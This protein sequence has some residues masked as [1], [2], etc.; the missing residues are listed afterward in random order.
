MSVAYLLR[1]QAGGMLATRVFLQPPT[2]AQMEAVGEEADSVFGPGWL[3][4][5]EV[6]LIE[7]GTVPA[8]NIRDNSGES[9]EPGV[10][11]GGVPLMIGAGVGGVVNPPGF[12][13]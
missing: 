6:L 12:D 3:K 1:H 9:Y 8:V 2:D 4:V 13:P 11:G 10:G 5:C 7:D